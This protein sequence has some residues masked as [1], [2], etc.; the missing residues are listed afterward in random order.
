[1]CPQFDNKHPIR[2][3]RSM[4]E[5]TLDQGVINLSDIT[6]EDESLPAHI[7]EK[8]LRKRIRGDRFMAIAV[9]SFAVLDAV[10]AG[11]FFADTLQGVRGHYDSVY[12]AQVINS[13]LGI[14]F[15]T[16]AIINGFSA[17]ENAKSAG[18]N[19]LKLAHVQ[20]L[21]GTAPVRR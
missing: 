13:L 6:R 18:K 3:N 7:A 2:Y 5:A 20:N 12:D 10:I 17:S 21:L 9:G 1:M 4:I 15:T 16:F 8:T 19:K 11:T 14:S